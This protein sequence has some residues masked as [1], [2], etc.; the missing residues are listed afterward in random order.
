MKKIIFGILFSCLSLTI[1][2]CGDVKEESTYDTTIPTATSTTDNDTT[3]DNTTTDNTTTDNT[4]TDNTTTDNTTSTDT[5][6]PTVSSI[7]P[8]DNQTAVLISENISITFSEAIATTSVSTNTSN[9]S[10]SGSVQLS[11]DNF[12]NCVQ[13]SSSPSSSNSDSTFTIDPSDDLSYSTTYK[14]QVTKAVKDSSGNFLSNKYESTNGFVTTSWAGTQLLGVPSPN[15]STPENGRGIALDSSNNI[16]ITGEA[17]NNGDS[18]GD[19]GLD[20]NTFLG[21]EDIFLV[22]YSS[23]GVKQW[24]KQF[25]TATNDI[26]KGIAIDSSNNIYLAGETSG[27]LDSQTNAGGKDIFLVKYN[28]GGTRQWTKLLG[29]SSEEVTNGIAIDSSNNIYITGY[30][31]GA[32]DSQTNSGSTDLFLVKY[33]SSGTKQWTKLLGT[34]THEYAYGIAV[35]SSNNIYLTGG[36]YGAL[37]GQTNSGRWDIFLVKFDSSGTKKWTKLLGNSEDQYGYGVTVDSSNNISVTGNTLGELDNQT[38]SGYEDIFLVK[39]NS[40]G[41]K[42]WTK[43]FGTS[44][45]YEAGFGVTSDSSDNLYVTG[46]TTGALDGSTNSY[47][48]YDIFLIK[49]NSSGTKQWTKQLGAGSSSSETGQG[50]TV[51][52]LSNIFITGGTGGA[53]DGGEYSGSTDIFLVKYNSSGTIQ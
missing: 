51:D 52:N 6:A 4:T 41:T 42:Q 17:G 9:T 35:D 11:S 13:M 23:N 3:T 33:N 53:L 34:S 12:S 50:V 7:S 30:T 2:S 40:S 44:S 5:T 14:I 16:Y 45:A 28:S 20:G 49:Y 10:C 19:V 46:R 29:T 15:S 38:N 25:G 31:E 22:K 21:V 43:L 32:L 39:Y 1:F 18:S 27:A 37:D 8:T 24:T 48:G 47:N 26:A 36:T